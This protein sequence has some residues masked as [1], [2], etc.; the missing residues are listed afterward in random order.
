MKKQGY[1]FLLV[2]IF[3][4]ASSFQLFKTSLQ[5]T[6]LNSLG[7]TVED[8]KVTLYSTYDD[9]LEETNPVAE[10][11]MTDNKGRVHFKDLKPKPYYVRVVKGDMSNTGEGEMVDTLVE[12]RKNKVNIVIQ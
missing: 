7:N 5:I 9:Y 12:K 3:T 8:A 11:Q 6:V 1:I 10:P 4:T 2:L